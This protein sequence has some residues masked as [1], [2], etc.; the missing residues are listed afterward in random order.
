MEESLESQVRAEQSGSAEHSSWQ[1]SGLA[2]WIQSF[3]I[4]IYFCKY[5]EYYKHCYEFVVERNVP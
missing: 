5:F 3:Y 1:P 4:A 2:T